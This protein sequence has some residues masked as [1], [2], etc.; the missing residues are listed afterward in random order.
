MRGLNT[1]AEAST[2]FVSFSLHID[3]SFN[4]LLLQREE[5]QQ[6]HMHLLQIIESERTA[7]W[8]YHQQCDELSL[9]IKKL[10]T[11]VSHI[12]CIAIYLPH[13]IFTDNSSPCYARF[14]FH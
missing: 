6:K 8:H 4:K 13:D 1:C 14:Y 3:S 10:R 12:S 5:L 11:E 9:E 7:K 2:N